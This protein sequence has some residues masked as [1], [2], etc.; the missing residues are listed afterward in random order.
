MSP[1]T[2]LSV[3]IEAW[4]RR[5]EVLEVGIAWIANADAWRAGSMHAAHYIIK[6]FEHLRNRTFVADNRDRFNFG[7]SE[8]VS[9]GE[10]ASALRELLDALAKQ[11][12]PVRLVG[13]SISQDIAWL[14]DTGVDLAD[15]ETC[16][17]AQVDYARR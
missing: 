3:D 6:E 1:G 9:Y 5:T 13:H 14:A 8:H 4:E 12:G 2:L 7:T 15:M 16:D 17:I 10:C 11:G